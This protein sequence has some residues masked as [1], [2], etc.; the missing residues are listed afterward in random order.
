MANICEL[1]L[2]T[3]K[4]NKPK[5]LTGLSQKARSRTTHFRIGLHGHHDYRWKGRAL[6]VLVTHVEHDKPVSLP[7]GAGRPQGML[8]VMRVEECGKS[9]C[10]PVMGWIGIEPQGNIIP[11]ESGQ[12][13]TWSFSTRKLVQPSIRGSCR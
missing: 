9:E 11:R 7:S 5:A 1:L 10:H 8:L 6:P 4:F 3:V 2:N 12:T 13:S